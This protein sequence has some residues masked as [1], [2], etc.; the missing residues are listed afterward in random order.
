MITE[1]LLTS[2][3]EA[4]KEK[5][6]H[7]RYE[8]TLGVEREIRVLARFFLPEKEREAAAA[9]L[10]HDITKGLSNEDHLALCAQAGACITEGERM[11]PALLHAKTAALL[12]P[13][14]YPDFATEEIL[15]AVAKHTAACPEMSVLDALLYIADFTEEGRSYSS[16][17]SVRRSLHN[18]ME[19]TRKEEKNLLLRR[20]LLETYN[21][22]LSALE[23]MGSPVASAT[24]E[25]REALLKNEA[26]F[27]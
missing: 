20:I 22:S 10:L 8:H 16:C 23:R 15:S 24:V 1:T 13:R 7:S 4:L 25:A 17:L 27:S 6:K 14:E 26:Y 5:M 9:G 12:I 2:L 3:R 11:I 18:G 21:A 19:N